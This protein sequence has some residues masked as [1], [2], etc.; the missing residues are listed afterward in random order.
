MFQLRT[1]TPLDLG[2]VANFYVAILLIPAPPFSPR[3]LVSAMEGYPLM[4][5]P[6][7]P[8]RLS[9]LHIGSFSH[10]GF[11]CIHFKIPRPV[12]PCIRLRY[13]PDSP[14]LATPSE[15]PTPRPCLRQNIFLR[16]TGLLPSR[17]LPP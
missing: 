17:R 2:S 16:R 1:G 5:L 15:L 12:A 4:P 3:H 10:P 14:A 11:T 6:F 8:C 7:L 13:L 9:C